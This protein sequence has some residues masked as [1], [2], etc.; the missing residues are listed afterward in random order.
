MVVKRDTKNFET[1][2]GSQ[3]QICSLGLDFTNIISVFEFHL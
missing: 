2:V 3:V 1:Y